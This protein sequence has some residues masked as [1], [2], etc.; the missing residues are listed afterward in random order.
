MQGNFAPRLRYAIITIQ[1]ISD[2]YYMALY[3]G[4]KQ[5]VLPSQKNLHRSTG[6]TKTPNARFQARLSLENRTTIPYACFCT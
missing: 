6:I 4:G 2:N 1:Y 3:C 5:N